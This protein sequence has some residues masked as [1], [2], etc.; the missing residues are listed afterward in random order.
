MA[1][2][3]AG[4]DAASDQSGFRIYGNRK[5]LIREIFGRDGLA[6]EQA[7]H[8]PNSAKQ[9]PGASPRPGRIDLCP[10]PMGTVQVLG[11]STMDA[12]GVH[13]KFEETSFQRGFAAVIP[14]T[15]IR[16]YSRC[17]YNPGSLQT[18]STACLVNSV[19]P[20]IRVPSHRRSMQTQLFSIR[21]PKFVRRYH[22]FVSHDLY[23][24]PSHAANIGGPDKTTAPPAHRLSSGS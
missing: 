10:K 11:L 12:L 24:V 1:A 13:A 14:I 6:S 19:Q 22:G 18:S 5:A 21:I 15:S 23:L 9:T 16:I 3:G 2:F 20:F 4:G 8:V 17:V 7:L